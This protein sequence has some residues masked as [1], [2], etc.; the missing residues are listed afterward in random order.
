[1]AEVDTP[2]SIKH[3]TLVHKQLRSYMLYQDLM[4]VGGVFFVALT[5]TQI[6]LNRDKQTQPTATTGS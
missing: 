6:S 3:R 4:P 1:M 5:D 2:T